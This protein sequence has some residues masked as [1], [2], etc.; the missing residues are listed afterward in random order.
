MN[1][2]SNGTPRTGF[3]VRGIVL[4]ESSLPAPREAQSILG[5]FVLAEE[6]IAIEHHSVF[7][8]WMPR[9]IQ[10]ANVKFHWSMPQVTAWIKGNQSMEH[11]PD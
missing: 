5:P 3:R 6:I 4:P 9:R 10:Y 7:A 1:A 2:P 11:M 8:Q